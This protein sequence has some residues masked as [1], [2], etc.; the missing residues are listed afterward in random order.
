MSVANAICH[1]VRM[2]AAQKSSVRNWSHKAA[3]VGNAYGN[4]ETC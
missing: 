1:V 2:I 4:L 3:G